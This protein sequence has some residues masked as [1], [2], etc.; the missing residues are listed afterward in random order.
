MMI[1]QR[2]RTWVGK[3]LV[4]G[5]LAFVGVGLVGCDNAANTQQDRE[6]PRDSVVH[7]N[8]ESVQ[9]TMNNIR[10]VLHEKIRPM[11]KDTMQNF[12][13]VS[14]PNAIDDHQATQT[15]ATPHNTD[16]FDFIK[17]NGF[18][19]A[20]DTPLS[21]FGA[22]VDSASYALVRYAI[23]RGYI[24]NPGAVRIEELLNSF[25]YDYKAP[26]DKPLAIYADMSDALW[27]PQHKILRIG[28]QAQKIDWE[29]RP[30]SNL[31]FLIDTSGSMMG[32]ERIGLVQKSLNMLVSKLDTRD[33]VGIVTYAGNAG[34]LLEPTNDKEKIL[35]AI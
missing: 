28:I 27:N 2:M 16:S 25:E 11:S 32:E 6:E 9:G 22:D 29:H 23:E 26:K 21:T 17:E 14:K 3:C 7:E 35:S 24:P 4:F 19:A 8:A 18:K 34:I 30:A 13:I 15:K 31:I 20:L 10:P 33:T 5:L 1:T 12:N